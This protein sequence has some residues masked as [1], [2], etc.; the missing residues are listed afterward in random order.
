MCI[1]IR[2]TSD[3]AGRIPGPLGKME[4]YSPVMG[5]HHLV[6]PRVITRF[7]MG[8]LLAVFAYSCLFFSIFAT[9]GCSQGKSDFE[10]LLEGNSEIS[11]A[12]VEFEL[13]KRQI[14]VDDSVSLDFLTKAL[15]VSKKGKG[16]LGTTV[17]A[18]IRL[19]TGYSTRCAVYFPKEPGTITFHFPI[20]GFGDGILYAV[21]IRGPIPNRLV[22]VFGE[23]K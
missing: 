23:L 14:I 9:L 22:E 3:Q 13:E 19:S 20:D 1:E 21:P 5:I 4:A 7:T 2:L 10:R 6:W 12:S 11:L 16:E 8:R 15:R 18:R 17:Y